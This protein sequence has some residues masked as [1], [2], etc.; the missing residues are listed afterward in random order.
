MADQ[1]EIDP[2]KVQNQHPDYAEDVSG[3]DDVESQP[4]IGTDPM[5]G[6]QEG[7]HKTIVSPDPDKVRE[8]ERKKAGRD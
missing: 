1:P 8:A 5:E 6:P 4:H 2:K 3:S 7:K